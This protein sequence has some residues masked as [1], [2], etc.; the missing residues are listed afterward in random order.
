MYDSLPIMH[1][2]L[3]N[4]YVKEV[5]DKNTHKD[6]PVIIATTSAPKTVP[7]PTKITKALL[8]HKKELCHSKTEALRAD[9]LPLVDHHQN[10]FSKYMDV[11]DS[12]I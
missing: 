5:L 12:L 7:S 2:T 3:A 9:R 11:E 8:D 4:M 1:L 10:L 6:A